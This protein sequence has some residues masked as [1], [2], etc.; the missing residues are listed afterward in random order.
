M[1]SRAAARL[2]I[3]RITRALGLIAS[4]ATPV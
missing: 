2:N 3:D 4:I 1:F